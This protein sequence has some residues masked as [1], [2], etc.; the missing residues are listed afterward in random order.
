MTPDFN[1]G[2]RT[3]LALSYFEEGY[4]CAQSVVLA[5]CDIIGLDKETA[6]KMS[7]SFGGGIG[8]MREVCGTITAMAM[9]AGFRYPAANP[10]DKGL[11][12]LNYS[13]VRKM[14]ELFRQSNGTIKCSELV[15]QVKA[16]T[17]PVPPA[18]AACIAKRPCARL[19]AE[20]ADIAGRML[21]GEFAERNNYINRK[22]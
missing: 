21:K 9:M 1:I 20:A 3:E 17:R 5:Y 19:V 11:Y 15:R 10:T 7:L 2:Q 14:T 22:Q 18:M 12:T 8:R 4:N 16:D 6:A 13:V